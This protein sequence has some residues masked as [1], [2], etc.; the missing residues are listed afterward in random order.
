MLDDQVTHP[1]GST[2]QHPSVSTA[3]GLL[4]DHIV[5]GLCAIY[6]F[7]PFQMGDD[8]TAFLYLSVASSTGRK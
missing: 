4:I 5:A 7:A 6:V 8:G 2:Y 3:V 1:Q